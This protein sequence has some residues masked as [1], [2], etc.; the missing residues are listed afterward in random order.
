MKILTNMGLL[1]E[2][3][4]SREC[5]V[6]RWFEGLNYDRGNLMFEAH[7]K[8]LSMETATEIGISSLAND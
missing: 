8:I 5:S 7:S 2:A 1:P 6:N 3:V 4:I